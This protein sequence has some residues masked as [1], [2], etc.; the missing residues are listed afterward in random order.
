MHFE[1]TYTYSSHIVK[2][3]LYILKVFRLSLMLWNNLK[4]FK[5]QKTAGSDLSLLLS[6]FFFF[7]YN[8]TIM[9]ELIRQDIIM[10]KSISPVSNSHS[11][12]TISIIIR[13]SFVIECLFSVLEAR[14]EI[15]Y[16]HMELC[17]DK[18][19]CQICMD[20]AVFLKNVLKVNHFWGSLQ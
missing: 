18:S 5:D 10:L 9:G 2:I 15:I 8:F 6:I 14:K 7:S 16:D 4:I 3:K 17:M 20:S 13:H 1:K 19:I 12:Q 11:V